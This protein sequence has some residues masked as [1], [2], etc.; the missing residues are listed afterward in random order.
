ML[1]LY[2]KFKKNRMDF[3]AAKIYKLIGKLQHYDWGGRRF[4]PSLLGINTND[5]PYAEYWMGAHEICSSEVELNENTKIPLRELI[6]E[7]D[8]RTP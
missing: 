5:L 3:D 6:Q 8:S 1:Y 4:I 2:F 7:A